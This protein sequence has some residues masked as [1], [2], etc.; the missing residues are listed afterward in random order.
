MAKTIRLTV[1]QALVKFLNNQYVEFDGKEDKMFEGVF[2]IFGHGNVVGMGQALQEDAGT[3]K[4]HMGRNEQGYT[5]FTTSSKWLFQNP[6]V[7]Y[8]NINVS[9]FHAD[10][11]D[12]V[13]VVAD[14]KL[15]LEAIDKEL[16]KTGWQLSDEFKAAV[17]DAK[18]KHEAEVDRFTA[19]NTRAKILFPKSSA[20]QEVYPA[21]FSAYGGLNP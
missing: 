14:A 21:T 7:E 2:G 11:M 3:L 18:E 13:Q 9:K 20:R 8:L 17:K 12:G 6:E 10:K 15:A 1:A 5:D 19:S 4:V 16:E